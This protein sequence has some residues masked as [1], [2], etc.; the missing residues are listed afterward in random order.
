LSGVVEL[1]HPR[2]SQRVRMDVSKNVDCLARLSIHCQ[3][4]TWLVPVRV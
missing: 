3:S 1:S 4:S 2:G